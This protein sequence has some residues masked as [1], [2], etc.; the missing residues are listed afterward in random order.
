MSL[1]CILKGQTIASACASLRNAKPERAPR[2]RRALN[3]AH[4]ALR[5][6]KRDFVAMLGRATPD[7]RSA[8][9]TAI[10]VITGDI[11]MIDRAL[12]S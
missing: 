11:R 1:D 5:A 10:N 9:L 12:N 6:R 2:I 3:G 7:R 8:I 4:S